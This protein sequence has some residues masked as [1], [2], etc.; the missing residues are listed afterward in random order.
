MPSVIN[1]WQLTWCW[2]SVDNDYHQQHF[3]WSSYLSQYWWLR[4]MLN[5]KLFNLVAVGLLI[6]S[7]AV[8]SSRKELSA[9]HCT[10]CCCRRHFVR[11]SERLLLSHVRTLHGFF[12]RTSSCRNLQGL[13]SKWLFNLPQHLNRCQYGDY[14]WPCMAIW[15][16]VSTAADP[17]AFK[18]AV[19]GLRCER[20]WEG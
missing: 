3:K 16:L 7:V 8:V 20:D 19:G 18:L 12:S 1:K 14:A 2:T 4:A 5:L 11:K 13:P 10:C 15:W 6:L 17:F 9:H